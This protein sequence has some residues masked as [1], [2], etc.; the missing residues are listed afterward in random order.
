MKSKIGL[1]VGGSGALGGSIV[2][3]FKKNGW[4]M[5]NIDMRPNE[6]A[7]SNFLLLPQKKI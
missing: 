1:I 3:A 4:R 2:N 7:D 5:L 6:E